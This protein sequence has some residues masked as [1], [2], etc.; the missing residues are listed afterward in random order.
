MQ[1]SEL[2]PVQTMLLQLNVPNQSKP[3]T[4]PGKSTKVLTIK[5]PKQEVPIKFPKQQIKSPKVSKQKEVQA[6]IKTLAAKLR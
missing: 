3:T 2:V 4:T 5:S 1:P 6:E